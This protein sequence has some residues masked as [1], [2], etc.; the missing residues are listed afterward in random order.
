FRQHVFPHPPG[1]VGP[2]ARNEAGAHLCAKLFIASAALAARSCQPA[3]EPISRDTERLAQPTRR[4]DPPVF[5]NE[6]LHV[7]SFAKWAAAWRRRRRRGVNL[8]AGPTLGTPCGP[9][10]GSPRP[11]SGEKTHQRPTGAAL[12]L[13]NFLGSAFGEGVPPPAP[14]QR[15]RQPARP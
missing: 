5:R 1:A 8:G 4:P 15:T 9:A 14:R 3:I 10:V 6:E 12:E 13:W 2:V 11:I 7:D